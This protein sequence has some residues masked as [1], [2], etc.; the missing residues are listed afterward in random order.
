MKLFLAGMESYIPL[1]FKER[2]KYVLFS[3]A[4]ANDECIKYIN[5]PYCKD[6]ILDSGAFTF[7]NSK[8]SNKNVDFIEYTKL[9]WK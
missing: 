9:R 3:Y 5:S 6:Y 8:K 2:P 1:F 4:Y 7:L